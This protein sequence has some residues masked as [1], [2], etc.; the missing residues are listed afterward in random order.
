[1]IYAST[2]AFAL[3]RRTLMLVWTP[4][5]L[6]FTNIAAVVLFIEGISV[7]LS[8]CWLVCLSV[9]LPVHWF[10]WDY[11]NNHAL[12]LHFH[13]PTI[14]AKALCFRPSHCPICPSVLSFIRPSS[15]ILLPRYLVNGLNSFDETDREYLLALTD[16]L[17][18]LWRSKVKVT[19]V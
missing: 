18:V 19:A 16:D 6:L 2:T 1:M 17:I 11:S 14:S 3:P 10:I 12:F 9:C 13:H 5:C 8:V 7:C 4:E 15:Q